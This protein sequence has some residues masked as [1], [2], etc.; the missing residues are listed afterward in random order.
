M[1]FYTFIF[2]YLLMAFWSCNDTMAQTGYVATTTYRHALELSVGIGKIGKH[3]PKF[4]EIPT[5]PSTSLE[6]NFKW[7]ST[8]QK[9]WKQL[10]N[11]PDIGIAVG[12]F[13]FGNHDVYGSAWS[14]VPNY[15]RYYGRS[16]HFFTKIGIGI[17]YL[18]KT[19]NLESN[20]R[21]VV[22]GSHWNNST[23]FL[24]GWN[25]SFSPRQD[26]QISAGVNH[27]SNGSTALPNL[28]I[29]F[30]QIHLAWIQKSK[31]SKIEIQDKLPQH[32]KKWRLN[33]RLS[34]ATN[35]RSTTGSPL[36]PIYL[37][38][39]G[40]QKNLTLKNKIL[41]GIDADYNLGIK[42]LIDA[43]ENTVQ[44]KYLSAMKSAI[45]IAHEFNM[46][47]FG[48]NTQVGTYV[49]KGFLKPLPV[50]FKFGGVQYFKTYNSQRLYAGIFLKT[51]FG[52]AEFVELGIGY[53]W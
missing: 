24:I 11:Y 30:L 10:Y 20:P 14:L 49:H 13:Y 19:Y 12:Y 27:F 31:S 7:L 9:T 15:T 37:I 43:N 25:S 46:G 38:N 8:Q 16:R 2:F 18:N 52:T 6:L 22:I 36:Y 50:Y 28:G 40:V 47:S 51:H 1:K 17:A 34:L 3:S 32:D 29:N 42:D 21:N 5:Q 33:T 44:N 26:L 39:I 4:V 53:V 48:F 23:L 35:A 45:Y 41:F